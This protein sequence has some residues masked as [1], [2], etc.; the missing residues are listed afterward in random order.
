MIIVTPKVHST[1]YW[2]LTCLT[3]V[4]TMVR[5]RRETPTTKHRERLYD[6][7]IVSN[8]ASA[9]ISISACGCVSNDCE[10]D[11]VDIQ[12]GLTAKNYIDQIFRPH[13]ETNIDNHALADLSSFV[14]MRT[15]SRKAR[16]RQDILTNASSL[17]LSTKSQNINIIAN[18]WLALSR[19]TNCMNIL[20]IIAAELHEAVHNGWQDITQESI[21][22]LVVSVQRRLHDIAGISR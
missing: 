11:S 6:E 7:C 4:S 21:R 14:I 18:L 16:I 15:K 9:R 10:L 22:L 8:S 5:S 19:C 17:L 3:R 2:W 12:G 20:P 1:T 13:V